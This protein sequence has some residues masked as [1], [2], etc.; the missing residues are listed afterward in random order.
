MLKFIKNIFVKPLSEGSQLTETSPKEKQETSSHQ[1]G[2]NYIDLSLVKKTSLPPPPK[3]ETNQKSPDVLKA[4]N[5]KDDF[6]IFSSEGWLLE[7]SEVIPMAERPSRTI[8]KIYPYK[9]GI[10]IINRVKHDEGRRIAFTTVIQRRNKK[11]L[12]D[13]SV[14]LNY[15]IFRIGINPD[16]SNFILA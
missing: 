6:Q 13:K 9:D 12:I 4:L 8:H 7:K 5:K 14:E 10:L 11:G 16:K 15:E 1:Q 3:I 2:P